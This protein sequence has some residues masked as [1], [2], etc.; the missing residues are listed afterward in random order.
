VQVAT[1]SSSYGSE[2]RT[3]KFLPAALADGGS[4]DWSG[5]DLI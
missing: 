1:S 3:G 2:Q 5:E 4:D